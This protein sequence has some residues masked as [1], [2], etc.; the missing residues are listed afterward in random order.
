MDAALGQAI[1]NCSTNGLLV[2]D[3]S[4][5]VVAI[6]D[7]ACN[8]LDVNRH[9]LLG[10][11]LGE[12]METVRHYL[13]QTLYESREF[14]YAPHI[15]TYSGQPRL[16]RV[17]T[18]RL[19]DT[20]QNLI[21][22]MAII[23]EPTDI[24]KLASMVCD[25]LPIACFLFD[26][27]EQ[28]IHLNQSATR[29]LGYD[30]AEL[31]HL[32]AEEILRIIIHPNIH[33][34]PAVRYALHSGSISRQIRDRVRGKNGQMIAVVADIFPL[35]DT[36][37]TSVG[38]LTLLRKVEEEFVYFQGTAKFL[39]D[40][41]PEAVL[42]VD[43]QRMMVVYNRM[44]ED[45]V[46]IPRNTVLNVNLD[47]LLAQVS[48]DCLPILLALREGQEQYNQPCIIPISGEER[49]FLLDVRK[50]RGE[51]GESV[52]MIAVIREVTSL[53]EMDRAIQKSSRLSLIGELAAGMA[54]EIRN[55]LTAVRG[56]LQLLQTRAQSTALAEIY[57][58]SSIMVSELDRVN[59]LI[60]QFLMLGQ[61]RPKKRLLFDIDRLL[62][63]LALLF[64]N[65]S[66]MRE[67]AFQRKNGASLPPVEGDPE[68]LKQ[69][70]S[71][72]FTNALQAMDKGGRLTIETGYLPHSGQ[73]CIHF[74]D[75]GHGISPE[76][77]AK[78]FHPFFTTRENGTGLGLSISH[79][80]IDAHGGKLHISSVVGQG[81]TVKILLPTAP[82]A[83]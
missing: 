41:L 12:G 75:T 65:E 17:Q 18:R 74:V 57:E 9:Q 1:F 48:T 11:P 35:I 58:Y 14:N 53:R 56:F 10:Q 7:I 19:Y 6:N 3:N 66:L 49:E 71:N 31:L 5:C 55:P 21:G 8:L 23:S 16:I 13:Q 37:G 77:L 26:Y 79:Q 78:I 50:V 33:A 61:V 59:D 4:L 54:H 67:I 2:T 20:D 64:E 62:D 32:T 44:A 63:D 60:H 27:K 81:S 29:L 34:Q 24:L 40:I 43:N 46:G 83:C 52:G 39:L 73:V 72:L 22:C 76:H 47:K 42:A 25:S 36:F 80:I 82:P 38:A 30:P 69:V 70:F 15:Y 51:E 68:Q 45:W 28:L